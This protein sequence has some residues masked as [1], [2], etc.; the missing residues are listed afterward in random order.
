MN[1]TWF[2]TGAT[3]GI[4]AAIAKAALDAGNKVVATGRKLEAVNQAL[5]TAENL[6]P[7][8]LD[9]T[10]ADQVEIAVRTA[11]ERFGRIDVLVN[12][13]G[14]GLMGPFEETAPEDIRAQFE[15]NVFGL[16]AVTR[17][18]MPGMRQQRSGRI[19]NISSV[20]GLKGVWGASPYN[21]SKFAVEGFS[22]AI[23]QELAP[24]GVCVTSVSPGFFR[25]DFLDLSSAKYWVAPLPTT[26][27]PWPNSAPFTTT[28]TALKPAIRRNSPLSFSI[29]RS[30]RSLRFH[31]W[32]ARMPLNGPRVPSSSNKPNST[33]GGIFRRA[34]TAF[35]LKVILPDRLESAL[36]LTEWGFF[37]TDFLIKTSRRVWRWQD[38]LL[39]R[40]GR[41]IKAWPTSDLQSSAPCWSNC[42]K[43][44]RGCCDSHQLTVRSRTAESIVYFHGWP[45][46]RRP[47]DRSI[48][49]D[50]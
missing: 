27:R 3:R 25:T 11:I 4:G 23:A 17:A 10:R 1:K 18:V 12:N 28:A 34:P 20:A 44:S 32:R 43:W 6:L 37:R 26:P 24:F 40:G 2:I 16:M 33:R 7:L 38:Q 39:R 41:E 42:R 36:S 14:Y 50:Q 45:A 35:G 8:A 9:V 46:L 5:G 30:A 22:Q 13:A 21:A 29:S 31:S 19:F 48:Q 47:S 15:T 49:E